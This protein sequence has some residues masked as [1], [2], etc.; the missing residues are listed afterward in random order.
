MGFEGETVVI[1]NGEDVYI[2][3]PGKTHSKLNSAKKSSRNFLESLNEPNRY[4]L[5]VDEYAPRQ[6][7]CLWID[8]RGISAEVKEGHIAKLKSDVPVVV[9]S[10]GGK[11]KTRMEFKYRLTRPGTVNAMICSSNH[12]SKREAFAEETVRIK[13]EEELIEKQ[14]VAKKNPLKP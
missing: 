4:S 10:T 2:W 7:D 11:L 5:K 14:V 8:P 3:R 13:C 12:C 1:S 6:E 9:S